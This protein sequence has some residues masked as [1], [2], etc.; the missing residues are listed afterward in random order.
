M[1]RRPPIRPGPPGVAAIQLLPI[2]HHHKL[3][4]Q[5]PAVVGED[6]VLAKLPVIVDPAIALLANPPAFAVVA[7]LEFGN[8]VVSLDQ[9][10]RIP[11]V[12]EVAIV[13][14]TAAGVVGYLDAHSR[15]MLDLVQRIDLPAALGVIADGIEGIVRRAMVCRTTLASSQWASS[16]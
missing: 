10:L 3:G 6:E 5:I 11:S 12:G 2:A 8:A 9:G 14:G 1:D 15:Q 7:E 13:R 4:H 16:L